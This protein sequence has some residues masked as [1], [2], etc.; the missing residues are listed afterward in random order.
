MASSIAPTIAMQDDMEPPAQE[1]AVFGA[2][3][4]L[5]YADKCLLSISRPLAVAEDGQLQ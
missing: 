5:S 1:R 3:A 2:G 4:R